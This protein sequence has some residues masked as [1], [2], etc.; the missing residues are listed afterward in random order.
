MYSLLSQHTTACS[1][2][3][4][5]NKCIGTC[6]II[7]GLE[8]CVYRDAYFMAS[9]EVCRTLLG[10]PNTSSDLRG[11]RHACIKLT[12][13]KE[14]PCFFCRLDAAIV[15]HALDELHTESRMAEK[16]VSDQILRMHVIDGAA[17]ACVGEKSVPA[18]H[19][20]INSSGLNGQLNGFN[21]RFHCVASKAWMASLSS[22]RRSS[23]KASCWH[24]GALFCT[25]VRM[26]ISQ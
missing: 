24:F 6:I 20:A 14:D 5:W 8:F 15:K 11:L 10:S 13:V 21:V 1:P 7:S 19:S 26:R 2:Q 9:R 18:P 4:C 12:L 17:W 25:G 22:S 23:H 3:R 16:G